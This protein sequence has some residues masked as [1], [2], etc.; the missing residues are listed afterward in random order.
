MS[1]QRS[2]VVALLEEAMAEFETGNAGV[3]AA[4]IAALSDDHRRTTETLERMHAAVL[5][6]TRRTV[7]VVMHFMERHADRHLVLQDERAARIDR[8][9]RAAP[10]AAERGA[11]THSNAGQGTSGLPGGPSPSHPE[12]QLEL[13]TRDEHLRRE[14]I[15]GEE[16][17][18]VSGVH[19]SAP[20][21]TP[22][23]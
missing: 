12:G 22:R 18:G 2:N 1:K 8:S 14:G 4:L 5:A 3:G 19:T 20:G 15:S 17:L 10:Q 6:E 16:I 23:R 9:F 21:P 13:L 7:D 11:Q